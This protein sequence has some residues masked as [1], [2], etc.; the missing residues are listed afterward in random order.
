MSMLGLFD[1]EGTGQQKTFYSDVILS[2]EIVSL[3]LV[4]T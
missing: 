3:Y 4:Y 1:R 2:S